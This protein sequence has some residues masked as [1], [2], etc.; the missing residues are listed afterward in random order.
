MKLTKFALPLLLAIFAFIIYLFTAAPFML[1][2]DSARFVAAIV[3]LGVANPPEPLYVLLAH[4]F[5]YLPFGSIIFRIQLFSALSAAITLLVVYRLILLVL[6][7]LGDPSTSL[8]TSKGNRE[9]KGNLRVLAAFFGTAMLAFS[10]QFWSQAQN[11]ETFMLVTLIEV[12][13]LILLLKSNS[14]RSVFINLSIIAGILGLSTGTNPVI[15]SV[16]P[17]ILWMMWTKRKFL[18]IPGFIA[19]FSIGIAAVVL[20]HLYIPIRASANPFLNYW[21]AT[22]LENVWK[23]STGAGLNVFVPEIGRINGFTLS[24]EIFFKSSFH[25]IEFFFIKF[26]PVLVPFIILGGI[27]LWQKARYYFYLL[28]SIVL[29][30]FIFSGLYFSG[31]QESWFLVSDVVFVILAGLGFF[32]LMTEPEQI[33]PKSPFDFTQGRLKSLN[34]YSRYLILLT[35]IPL[36]FWWQALD[37]HSWVLTEDYI[38]NLY[39]PAGESKAILFGSSDVFDSIS[40][41]IYD[42]PAI[43]VYNRNVVPITDNL[44]YILKWYRENIALH[45]DLKIPDDSGLKYDSAQ[46]YS[47]FVNDFFA[48]NINTH[49]IFITVPAQRNNFLQAYRGQNLG[50]SLRIDESKFKLVPQGMFLQVVPKEA[51]DEPELKNFDYQ[52]KSP[53][54]PKKRPTLLEQTYKNELTGIINEYAYS[55]Q[56]LGDYFLNRSKAEEAFKYYQKAYDL[57]PKNAEIVSRLG[58]YYGSTGNHAKAAEFFE[59]ALKIESKNI[60]LL[61]NLAISYE[62]TGRIDKAISNY[63][64]ILQF[65]KGGEDQIAQLA[66]VRLQSLRSATPSAQ[67]A[68]GSGTLQEQLLPKASPGTQIYTSQLINIQFA[69]PQGFE[70]REDKNLVRLTNNLK[71]KDEL[72]FIFY[73]RKLASPTE[74]LEDLSKNLP[75]AI[76]GQVLITQQVGIEGFEALGKTYGGQSLTFLLLMKRGDLGVVIKIY[77]G[78]SAKS[79]EF[80][81]I[82]QSIKPLE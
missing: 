15:A 70:L 53:G 36:L 4:P 5:T 47:R 18:T 13:I 77:P 80:N 40:P 7:N 26:T 81:Q 34:K 59:K 76:D 82:I 3:T 23:A 56:S 22:T 79:A 37:R 31:N 20:I 46:E 65:S 42:V 75:F 12:V 19:W 32:W 43:G 28:I 50:P 48:L 21:R 52:F 63:N 41:L 72:T 55:Y 9:D 24:P 6:E 39:Q 8:R 2:L 64:K 74:S 11:I 27:F 67:A 51:T 29:T 14:K 78:D 30:N 57:N 69:Y 71:D 25:F 1:W 54:F 49:K 45:S 33:I 60:G 35:L 58:N 61:F 66:K 62:N 68:T 44:L 38:K 10:Y 73:G 17:A 16:V